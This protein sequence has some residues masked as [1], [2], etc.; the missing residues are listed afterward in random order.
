MDPAIIYGNL[1]VITAIKPIATT[2]H[3]AHYNLF[4]DY[5]RRGQAINQTAKDL[6]KT[7]KKFDIITHR[8]ILEERINDLD[9]RYKNR[10]PLNE[11]VKQIPSSGIVNG[12]SFLVGYIVGY[13]ITALTQ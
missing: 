8:K 3:I 11:G 9:S 4:T 6:E 12:L 7:G 2:V 10:N 1:A 13:G 5:E